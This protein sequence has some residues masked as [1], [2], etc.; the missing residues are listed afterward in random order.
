MSPRRQSAEVRDEGVALL[1]V[2]AFTAFVGLV[3]AS[4]AALIITSLQ[5]TADLQ[6]L[7]DTEYSAASAIDLQVE[8]LRN[9]Q[10]LAHATGS[11]PGFT[12]DVDGSVVTLTC[13][14]PGTAYLG[15]DLDFTASIDGEV[16]LSASVHIGLGPDPVVN[17]NEWEYD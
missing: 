11:C 5:S 13:T 6:E 12:A 14:N 7:R 17:V 10:D 9:D 15:R 1:L 16:V 4:V 3:L 2:L 8:Y